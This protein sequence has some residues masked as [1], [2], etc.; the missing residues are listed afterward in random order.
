MIRPSI[1]LLTRGG[2]CSVHLVAGQGWVALS[3]VAD[4]GG[5][6]LRTAGYVESLG[7]WPLLL[8]KNGLRA[9]LEPGLEA[10]VELTI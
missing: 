6:D 9:S 10:L 2:F 1:R 5:L 7:L 8:A 4:Q 3:P